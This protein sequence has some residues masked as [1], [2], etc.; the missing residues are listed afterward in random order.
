M[1]REQRTAVELHR[2]SRILSVT[3]SVAGS[4]AAARTSK[5]ADTA[6]TMMCVLLNTAGSAGASHI[7]IRYNMDWVVV[8]SAYTAQKLDAPR[9]G[10]IRCEREYGRTPSTGNDSGP[11][12]GGHCEGARRLLIEALEI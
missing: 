3:A 8:S 4:F 12:D 5:T 11:L 10:G 1:I 6:A 2:W 9:T 7:F